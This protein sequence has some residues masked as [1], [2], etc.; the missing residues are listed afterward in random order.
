MR[1][2]LR[3]RLALARRELELKLKQ[4]GDP[5][6]ARLASTHPVP[7]DA[8][9]KRQQ[10]AERH[11]MAPPPGRVEAPATIDQPLD[12]REQTILS[13]RLAPA[14]RHALARGVAPPENTGRKRED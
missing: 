4:A 6:G 12:P 10:V 14:L 1:D 11:G 9:A 13:Y 5:A 3:I 2:A 7:E 8:E